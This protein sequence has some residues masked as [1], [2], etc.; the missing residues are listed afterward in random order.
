MSDEEE[1]LTLEETISSVAA[2]FLIGLLMTG[3]P[4]DIDNILTAA[5]EIGRLSAQEWEYQNGH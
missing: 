3:A 4:I 5:K 2:G 1:G